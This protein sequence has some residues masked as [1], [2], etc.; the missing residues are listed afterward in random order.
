[1]GKY[2]TELL[3][4]SLG[5]INNQI[6]YSSLRLGALAGGAP[7]LVE[8]DFLSKIARKAYEGKPI[9]IVGGM[10]K[11]ERLDIRDAVAAIL[12]ML[13]TNSDSWK[14]IYNLSSG[15]VLRLKEIT[16]EIVNVVS[17][18]NGGMKSVINIE[19]NEVKMAFGMDSIL[20]RADMKWKPKYFLEDTIE[21]L[22][23]YFI[24]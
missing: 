10:Q 20:F 16:K 7:G 15:E 21:S 1:M 17:K 8:V 6:N 5:K 14:P 12:A 23:Q 11:M 24:K 13:N 3:L 2:A 22:V 19:P 9:D 4:E 18:N